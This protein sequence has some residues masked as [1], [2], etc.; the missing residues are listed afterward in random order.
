METLQ[1]TILLIDAIQSIY[2]MKLEVEAYE[3]KHGEDERLKKT[4][5]R[6]DKIQK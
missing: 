1:K 3:S 2:E 5:E 6:I 4:K